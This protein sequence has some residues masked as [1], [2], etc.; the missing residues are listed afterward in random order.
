MPF[1]A[2]ITGDGIVSRLTLPGVTVMAGGD[3]VSN[4][5]AA[6]ITPAGLDTAIRFTAAS[7][8][9]SWNGVLI[10]FAGGAPAAGS[11]SAVY[12]PANKTL[13][14][15][16]KTDLIENMTYSANVYGGTLSAVGAPLASQFF[17]QFRTYIIPVVV[18][19]NPIGQD[20]PL[21]TAITISFN[22]SM[23]RSS[24]EASIVIA[25]NF[26]WSPSWSADKSSRFVT[27]LPPVAFASFSMSDFF[28]LR[29]AM[30][31]FLARKCCAM[32]SMPFWQNTNIRT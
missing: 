15:I 24:V 13:T 22:V 11:E 20:E 1:R 9:T 8:G 12:T 31:P 17:W 29:T 19:H 14:I 3:D 18:S 30:I 26:P 28:A 4:Q 27:I 25:P 6:A 5:A 16:P 32:S 7:V 10:T 23:N 2:S 21:N